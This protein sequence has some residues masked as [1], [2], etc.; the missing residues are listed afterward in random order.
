MNESAPAM[1]LVGNADFLAAQRGDKSAFARLVLSTQKAVATIALAVTRDVQLS[2]DIA[3]N[4]YTKAWQRLPSMQNPESFLPWL[5]EVTRNE[6][7][8]NVRRR[9]LQE[10]ALG[11]DD[12]RI[13]DAAAQGPEPDSWLHDRQRAEQL[14]RALDAVPEDSRE[15]LLLFYREGKSSR[16]VAALLGLSDGAVRKRLQRA[17]DAL[18]SEWLAQVAE[19]SR[20]SAP[21]LAFATLVVGSLG[22][23]DAA[24]ATLASST[25]GKWALGAV[26]SVLA[27][28]AVVLGAVWIDV[29]LAM[30]RARNPAE[31]RELL[32][33][34]IVYAAVMASFIGMLFWSKHGDWSQAR[35][36]V[37][38]GLYSLV[39][40]G[41]GV[42]RAGIHRRNRGGH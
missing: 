5:R 26:G 11:M 1:T 6:A 18:Q 39:I 23:R 28:L 40:I 10:F 25:A 21:G 19:V 16:H 24:A 13:T 9:R 31:R 14:A 32:R 37:V 41:L 4:A 42:A 20:H 29:R 7:I 38:S 33:H 35:L 3:Q 8:D 12:P 36:L 15:V 34:G 17:R 2:E 30:R 27:A 22:P